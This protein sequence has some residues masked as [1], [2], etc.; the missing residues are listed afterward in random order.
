MGPLPGEGSGSGGGG[1]VTDDGVR[2]VPPDGGP[3]LVSNATRYKHLLTDI[4][5]ISRCNWVQR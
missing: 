5:K 3:G 2:Q 4:G 1:A